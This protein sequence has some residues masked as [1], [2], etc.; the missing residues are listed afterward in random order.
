MLFKFVC[1]TF[2]ALFF[3]YDKNLHFYDVK[4][5]SCLYEHILA[6]TKILTLALI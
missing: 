6:S 4:F 3:S 2:T 1:D 5:W